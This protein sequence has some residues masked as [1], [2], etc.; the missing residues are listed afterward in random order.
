VGHAEIVCVNDQQLC[1]AWIAESFGN[2]FFL[3]TDLSEW[4]QRK[5]GDCD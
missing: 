1:V 5:D 3:T 4:K 2:R